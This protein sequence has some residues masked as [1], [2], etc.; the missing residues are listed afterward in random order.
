MEDAVRSAPQLPTEA[1]R[2]RCLHGCRNSFR[3]PSL[4]FEGACGSEGGNCA[5]KLAID[6]ALKL[7]ERHSQQCDIELALQY[8]G[9]LA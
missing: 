5:C 8:E 9:D 2:T 3:S 6:D 7:K 4:E 1:V